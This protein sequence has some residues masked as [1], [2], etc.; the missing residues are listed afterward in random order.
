MTRELLGAEY[1][2]VV[3]AFVADARM[4]CVALAQAASSSDHVELRRLAHSV[5]GAARNLGATAL[6]VAAAELEATAA[7]RGMSGAS[8][9]AHWLRAL[10]VCIDATEMVLLATPE[11]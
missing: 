11:P 10:R 5:K 3:A 6:A 7:A 9:S 1:M 2:P 8:D 4:K